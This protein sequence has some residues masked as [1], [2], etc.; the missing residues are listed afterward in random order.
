MSREVRSTFQVKKTTGCYPE[1]RVDAKGLFAVER[2]G[3][4]I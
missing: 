2:G 4:L 1:P 3:V